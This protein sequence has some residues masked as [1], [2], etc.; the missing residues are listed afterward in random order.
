MKKNS[1]EIRTTFNNTLHLSKHHDALPKAS[2][3]SM[4][5]G[6]SALQKT[7]R[8]SGTINSMENFERETYMQLWF[9]KGTTTTWIFGTKRKIWSVTLQPLRLRTVCSSAFCSIE[10][11]EIS[12]SCTRITCWKQICVHIEA[13]LQI[14]TFKH[15][16]NKKSKYTSFLLIHANVIWNALPCRESIW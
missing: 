7:N 8:Q 12:R 13:N 14:Y 9:R 3:T 11:C 16:G 4:L 10:S 1:K 2:C 15:H 6:N 5:Y